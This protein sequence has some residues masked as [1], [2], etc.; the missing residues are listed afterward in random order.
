MATPSE[1]KTA[2][3]ELQQRMVK[4][5]K[6]LHINL[7][8]KLSFIK[9]TLKYLCRP[10]IEKTSWDPVEN[11]RLYKRYMVNHC[12]QLD[13]LVIRRKLNACLGRVEEARADVPRLLRRAFL[14][15][16]TCPTQPDAES[17]MC[18]VHQFFSKYLGLRRQICGL[19]ARY[20]TSSPDTE[21]PS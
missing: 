19:I 14:G 15:G 8:S 4:C 9:Y 18:E 20:G 2:N 16:I 6:F 21:P 1:L 7:D 3:E 5:C 10:P 13:A 12:R 11:D 17:P